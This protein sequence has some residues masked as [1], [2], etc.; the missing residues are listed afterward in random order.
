MPCDPNSMFK[1]IKSFSVLIKKKKSKTIDYEQSEL[2]LYQN[3]VYREAGLNEQCLEHL[4]DNRRYILDKLC[5]E[6]TKGTELKN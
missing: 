2:L 1:K 4:Y 6:E 3:M 5:V